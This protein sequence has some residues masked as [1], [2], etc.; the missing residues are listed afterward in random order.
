MN[1]LFLTYQ[2]G[3]AGSTYSLAYLAA[4]LSQRNHQ[5]WVGCS[6]R[7]LLWKLL[8]ASLAHR[9]PMEIASRFDRT[10][11]TTIS[12]LVRTCSIDIINAQ[13][14][15]D[16][17]TSILARWLYQLPCKVVHTRRQLSKSQ[18]LAGKFHQLGTDK[19]IAV[20]QGV[21]QSLVSTGM[22]AEHIHVIYNG[23]PA[24]KYDTL[25]P[26]QVEALRVR[27]QIAEQDVVIG[28]VS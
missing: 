28:S 3:P 21:K 20:S 15:K 4:E 24:E 27:Y 22:R 5:V 19:I 26:S 14:S 18:L 1:I 8:D 12:K 23:T 25:N 10:N 6:S 2:G 11:I 7:S 9:V 17:Y 13:S 16:R